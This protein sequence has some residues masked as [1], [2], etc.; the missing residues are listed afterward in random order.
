M[1]PAAKQSSFVLSEAGDFS[2]KPC[3]CRQAFRCPIFAGS[4]GCADRTSP[5]LVSNQANPFGK[6]AELERRE[7]WHAAMEKYCALLFILPCVCPSAC[8]WSTAPSRSAPLAPE[9][10]VCPTHSCQ[11]AA[12]WRW[13]PV[14]KP[15]P[16][17]YRNEC[18]LL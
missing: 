14:I 15:N 1:V 7:G 3:P 18:N 17:F 12:S 13:S 11:L 6:P 9:G 2:E 4:V 8:C 5:Q 16:L 10:C